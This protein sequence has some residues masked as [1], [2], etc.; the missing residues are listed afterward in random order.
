MKTIFLQLATAIGF[1]VLMTKSVTAQNT[2]GNAIP[3][4]PYLFA[5]QH[6][7]VFFSTVGVPN[8]N[9]TAQPPFCT[10][11]VGTGGQRWYSMS[12]DNQIPL[13]TT[14]ETK[15]SSNGLF[16]TKLHVYTGYCG[17]LTCVAGDDDG[18]LGSYSKVT[19]IAQPNTTYLIRV[20]GYNGAEGVTNITLDAG[21][22]GCT[23]PS[24]YNYDWTAEWGQWN[25]L[26]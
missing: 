6:M 3:M 19:F 14:I 25:M 22:P 20:G 17:S 16:D 4:E 5:G 8:D 24:A 7:D 21:E 9:A 1:A 23:D 13:S 15:E 26:L 18:G 2:C 11:S 12:L 10:T